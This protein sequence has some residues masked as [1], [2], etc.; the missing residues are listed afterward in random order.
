[1]GYS[2]LEPRASA[3]PTVVSSPAWSAPW[4][5]RMYSM[6]YRG[7]TGRHVQE[8]EGT[9]LLPG[10][11]IQGDI[12]PPWENRRLFAHKPLFPKGERVPLCASFLLLL[13]ENGCL[14]AQRCS[15]S[16]G[17]TGASLRRGLLSSF[18]R[19]G[20]SLRRGLFFSPRENGC[21][22]AQRFLLFS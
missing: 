6:V 12:Y 9:T 21:L 16:S 1:M 13:R 20:A 7:G 22:S 15:S 10:R 3:H 5:G 2:L 17:R 19:T 4:V 18:G 14:S 8:S 11:H